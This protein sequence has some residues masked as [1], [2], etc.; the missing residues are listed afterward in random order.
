MATRPKPT[1]KIDDTIENA[2]SGYAARLITQGEHK[3]YTLT[4]PSDVLAKTCV[5][6][7]RV[8]NPI[9]GFQRTLDE[10]RAQ[11]IADYIDSGFGTIP[12]SIVLSAQPEAELIYTSKSQVLTFKHT[13]RSF[14]ILDGQHRVFGFHKANTSL[15][16]PVVIYNGL[17]RS[18]EARLFIDIN[19]K[20]RPVPN[21]L[22]LDIKRLADNESTE[23]SL[24]RDIFD[25]LDSKSDSPLFGLMSPSTRSKGKISRVTFRVAMKSIWN[26]IEDLSA[27]EAYDVLRTY[28]SVWAQT[29]RDNGAYENLTNSTMFRAIILFLPIIAQRVNDRFG[30]YTA[31][32]FNAVLQP[33]FSKLK[34]NHLKTPGS[35]PT[36]LFEEFEKTLSSGFAIRGIRS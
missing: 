24:Q 1:T 8:E 15:R 22:L 10:K 28:L 27:E 35:S 2:T 19:T 5:V 34:K 23:D 31:D 17:N 20:Q 6:D 11:E 16:V 4:L 3:F 13:P 12:C 18:Q 26:V 36:S 21:E 7:T 14:L 9:D 29:L 33:F 25:M 32:N 30:D